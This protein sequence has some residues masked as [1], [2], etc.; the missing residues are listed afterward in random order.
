MGL[1]PNN[2][3]DWDAIV[4][5]SVFSIN[6]ICRKVGVVRPTFM[7][8]IEQKDPSTPNKKNFERTVIAMEEALKNPRLPKHPSFGYATEDQ[9][10]RLKTLGIGPE[11][12]KLLSQID[13]QN[14]AKGKLV[15]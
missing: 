7:R 2:Q 10:K 1:N 13:K 15:Y 6:H 5:G 9:I 11:R 12:D 3:M 14:K 4:Y 8:W